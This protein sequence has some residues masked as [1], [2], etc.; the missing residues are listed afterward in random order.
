MR[1]ITLLAPLAAA[2][3]AGGVAL[4]QSGGGFDLSW[5]SVGGGVPSSMGGGYT[6]SG[7]VGQADAS[8]GLTGGVYTLVGGFWGIAATPAE[9]APTP[10]PTPTA[11]PGI[12]IWGL[13]MMA[14]LLLFTVLG[15]LTHIHTRQ[16][17]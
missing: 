17:G 6:L 8:S 16:R 5:S 11:V 3:L 14:G 15:R 1:R 12:A 7:T 13:L 4:A 2:L 10:T 9:P